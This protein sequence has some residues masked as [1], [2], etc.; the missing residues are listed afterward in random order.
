MNFPSLHESVATMHVGTE[1]NR[2]YYLPAAP[3]GAEGRILSLN[4]TWNFRYWDSFGRTFRDGM[5]ELKEADFDEIPVPSCWQMHGYDRHQ[6]TNYNYPIPFDPPYVPED[7][8]CGLYVRSFQVT[9]D[10]LGKKAYLNFEGVDSC[11]YLWI[12]DVFAGFTQVSHSTSEFDITDL[13]QEGEN[14]IAV[15]VLKWCLGTYFED[16]DKLRMSGIFRDVYLLFRPE[17]HIRDYFVKTPVAEDLQSAKVTVEV[18]P[19]G[20]AAVTAVLTAPDGTVIGEKALEAGYAAFD[21]AAPILWNAEAPAL[22]TLTLST[23]DEVIAQK[24]GICRREIKNRVVY[25]NGKAI[26][27]FGVNRHDSDPVT[28]YTISREQAMTDLVLMKQHNINAIRSS[29]YPN[30]PWF[31][32]LA[33]E[34]GFYVID[35]ADN[36]THGTTSYYGTYDIEG[37]DFSY[38]AM[39]EAYAP[40]MLDR[41][42][43]CVE[44]DKNQACVMIWSMGNECGYGGNFEAAGRWIKERDASRFT[45]YQGAYRAPKTRENDFSM[46]DI[47]GMFYLDY[48]VIETYC[49]NENNEKPCIQTEFIH[50]MGNGPGDIEGYME[51]ME[52]YDNFAG[53]FAWEWCDHSVYM[54]TTE[55]GRDKYFYGGDFGEKPHDGNF[56]MDGLVYPNRTPHVGLLEYK[57]CLRPIRASWKD[58]AQGVITLRN[59]MRFTPSCKFAAIGWE[60]RVDGEATAS[61][62]WENVCIAPEG[63]ADVTLPAPLPG[64]NASLVITYTAPEDTAFFEAGHVLGFDELLPTAAPA[65]LCDFTPAGKV[66]VT[67]KGADIIFTS[68]AFRYVADCQTGLFRSMTANNQELLTRPMEYNIWRAPTDNDMYAKLDWLKS[69]YDRHTVRVYEIEAEAL[70]TG[71]ASMTC[72]FGI[73]AVSK[74]KILDGKATWLIDENGTVDVTMEMQREPR[75]P[76]LPRFGLRMFLPSDFDTANYI[77]YGPWE[78]YRDKHRASTLGHYITAVCDNHEDYVRPQENSSHWGCRFVALERDGMTLEVESKNSFCFNVSPYTQEELTAK[79]HNFELVP[80]GDT[81]FCLD[82]GQSGVG[83]G[84]CGPQLRKSE[85]LNEAQFTAHF[86]LSVL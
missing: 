25:L 79:A 84:S 23:A 41:I 71:G 18:E 28:G 43:R 81:V 6:Y 67:R 13:L 59:L 62:A 20:D 85:Q 17:N 80:C 40:V 46:I 30:A 8:P 60:V 37:D 2:S 77:G 75:M 69:G 38:L 42:Q 72:R 76:Y 82:Y 35:E 9:A 52:K 31:Y 39:E 73:G 86:R 63:T 14:R 22:Y 4:G 66:T 15:L 27:F 10:Q 36:E 68:P 78:S 48:P 50:C 65:P 34:M 64:G 57:N 44:R 70:P 47:W 58:E 7:N 45:H 54:G 55:D 16:Q 11:L 74:H 61:G 12:N 21:V 1:P 49:S 53:G 56:C 5:P 26:K 83:S 33:S 51:L 32:E 3:D 24:V 29:H 19:E